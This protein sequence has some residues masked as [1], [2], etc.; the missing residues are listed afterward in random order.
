MDIHNS[1]E[2][3]RHKGPVMV[4][5]HT[6]FKGTWL[7]LLLL[8]L[9]IEVVGYS[10]KPSKNSIYNLLG[11]QGKT[12]EVYGD[13]RN[14]RALSKFIQTF[15]PSS[16]VHLAAQPLVLQSYKKP[17]LTFDVNVMGTINLLESSNK[18][19]EVESIVVA[20][21]DKV[22][23][24]TNFKYSFKEN[25]PLEG[26]DPYSSSKVGVE[27]VIS[28]W[29]N[30]FSKDS[31][32]K[33]ISARAGNVIGGGDLSEERIIP[34]CIRAHINKNVLVVRNPNSVRPW[35]HVLEPLV[36]YL[37]AL[38]Y[39]AHPAYNFGPIENENLS[40]MDVVKKV[41]DKIAFEFDVSMTKPD[42]Y[43]ASTLS[44]NSD[45]A[46]SFLG[47]R[48]IYNQREAINETVNWWQMY[49]AEKNMLEVT[50]E[51]IKC[52]IIK[53]KNLVGM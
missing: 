21:T 28:S 44:L 31:R 47:W 53:S 16:I 9:G 18:S 1:V 20:T 34:D 42:F 13:I 6:G 10:L 5:G 15:K 32:I 22:Y 51:Q 19:K 2:R 25:D 38:I 30:M 40:V 3:L 49:L 27:A 45:L 29:Q 39:G 23:K 14:E 46:N 4:T 11:L 43:E 8:E 52:Y 36:G 41:N 17:K 12:P 37:C 50:R 48:S 24:N 35:Q 7:T 33:L 26:I